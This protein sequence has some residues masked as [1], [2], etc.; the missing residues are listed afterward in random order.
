MKKA[1]IILAGLMLAFAPPAAAGRIH[2]GW[3]SQQDGRLRARAGARIDVQR[4]SAGH[5]KHRSQPTAT[6]AVHVRSGASSKS[7]GGAT[8]APLPQPM[9][10]PLSARS[11]L[12]KKTQ[13]YG[14]GSFWYRDSAGHLCQYVPNSTRICFTT[15]VTGTAAP[16]VP[17]LTPAT[18]AQHVA[19]RLTLSP[20]AVKSSPT[21]AG[22]TGA[23][24]WFWLDPAPATEHLSVS[25]AGEAVTVMAVP[26]VSWRFGDGGTLDGGAGIPYQPGPVP[27]TAI[28]HVYATRCLPGDQGRDPYVLASCGSDGYQLIAAVTWQISYRAHGPVAATGTLPTRTTSSSAAYPVSEARAFLVQAAT[29]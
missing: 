12:L 20:G 11:P 1:A 5:P 7:I 8:D 17:P 18:I 3:F 6:V 14:P 28:T 4:S 27:S 22:L 25:L 24:S 23:A 26:Q 2:V 29:G 21:G 13:P 10:P 9:Y 19:D 15:T 16:A